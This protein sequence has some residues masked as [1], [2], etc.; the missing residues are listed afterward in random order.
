MQGEDI[1]VLG[2]VS[3]LPS[4]SGATIAASSTR[5]RCC[6]SFRRLNSVMVSYLTG[7]VQSSKQKQPCA[8]LRMKPKV[9]FSIP[10]SL[11]AIGHVLIDGFTLRH[12]QLDLRMEVILH[13]Y[14]ENIHFGDARSVE[15]DC[16][17]LCQRG[18]TKYAEFTS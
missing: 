9:F 11:P 3:G 4:K 1:G 8:G 14:E 18:S 7:N 15:T 13:A 6:V 16:L 5:K 2:S 10:F 12:K 17:E